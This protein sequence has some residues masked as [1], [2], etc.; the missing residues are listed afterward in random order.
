MKSNKKHPSWLHSTVVGLSEA[1]SGGFLKRVKKDT[2]KQVFSCEY[3]KIFNATYFENYLRTTAFWIFKGSLLHRPKGLRCRLYDCVRLQGL[4]H[5]SSFL[6][7]SLHEPSPSP[8][9]LRSKIWGEYLW[10]INYSSYWL[11]LVVLVGFRISW[12]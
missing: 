6:F 7:L 9:D 8:P 10:W 1:A 3:C 2:P 5:R 12:F 4:S 11:F